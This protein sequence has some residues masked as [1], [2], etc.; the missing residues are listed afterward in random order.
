VSPDP[1]FIT[2]WA[3]DWLARGDEEVIRFHFVDHGPSYVIVS[4]C[5][6][7]CNETAGKKFRKF[8]ENGQT[9]EY[10]EKVLGYIEKNLE[11][12]PLIPPPIISDQFE[13]FVSWRVQAQ[14]EHFDILFTYRRM[15]NETGFDTIVH[16]DNNIRQARNYVREV[17]FGPDRT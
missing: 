1:N 13:K 5:T 7:A 6:V 8:R 11:K 2:D 17:K 4:T 3:V 15:G 10:I 12:S 9:A 14:R 16:L